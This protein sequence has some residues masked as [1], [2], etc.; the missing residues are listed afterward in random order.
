MAD[1]VLTLDAMLRQWRTLPAGDR[2]AILKHL[3]MERRIALEQALATRKGS[4]ATTE[5]DGE[6]REYAGYSPWLAEIV[7]RCMAE[8][9]GPAQIKPALRDAIRMAHA[10]IAT[11]PPVP[12]KPSLVELARTNL[13]Q[14]GIWL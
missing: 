10:H 13:K 11:Q 14:W 1:A 3:P 8:D 7:A 5:S 2:K 12:A 9:E 4:A 6:D